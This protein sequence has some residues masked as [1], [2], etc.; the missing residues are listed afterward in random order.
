[1]GGATATQPPRVEQFTLLNAD[2]GVEIM[3]L[4]E[5]AT[6]NLDV[7]PPHL[8]ARADTDPPMVGS[9]VLQ[10]DGGQP[11]TENTAP[12]VVTTENAPNNYMPWTLRPGSHTITATPWSAANAMGTVGAPLTVT[13]TL[14]SASS[15]AGGAPGIAGAAGA[16][17]FGTA[18][19]AALGAGGFVTAAGGTTGVAGS[20][21]AGNLVAA[22]GSFGVA[23][24]GGI[25][26]YPALNNAD[27][28]SSGFSCGCRVG[29]R[30]TPDAKSL[31]LAALAA[32]LGLRRR[33]RVSQR[34]ARR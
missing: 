18:G 34:T 32:G 3:P 16:A 21:T 33:R 25:A 27:G 7:L 29:E 19:T 6:V 24:F 11:T 22:A 1:M 23:G 12:Y 30:S 2:T 28:G 8:T 31:A 26:G 10:I 13:F 5:A 4:T 17:G 9:V 14:S 20:G 15:G